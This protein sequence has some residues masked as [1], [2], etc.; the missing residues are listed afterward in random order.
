MCN[1]Q[2]NAYSW[3][4]VLKF[5]VAVWSV[6]AVFYTGADVFGNDSLPGAHNVSAA[7]RAGGYNELRNSDTG[8]K[9]EQALD[10]R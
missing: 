5:S 7:G 6:K 10:W 1:M 8:D 3:I 4:W 9:H 2:Q